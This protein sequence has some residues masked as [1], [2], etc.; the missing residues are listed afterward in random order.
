VLSLCAPQANLVKQLGKL[1]KVRY[2]ED[3]TAT[4]RVG[5]WMRTFTACM[6][7]AVQS[8]GCLLCCTPSMRYTGMCPLDV[9][10]QL[11]QLCAHI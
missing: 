10:L 7:P 5:E 11:V 9:W 4:K 3:I 2:V 8:S 1:V 6:R